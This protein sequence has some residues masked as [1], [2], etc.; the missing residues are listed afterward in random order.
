MKRAMATK[1]IPPKPAPERKNAVVEQLA[2]SLSSALERRLE[3]ANATQR[4]E[5]TRKL[6]AL[7]ARSR[8]AS[9]KR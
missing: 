6:R 4:A 5:V 9:G 8:G 3:G 2:D 7:A 1:P